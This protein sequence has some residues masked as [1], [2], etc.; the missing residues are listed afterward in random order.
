MRL[1]MKETNFLSP[2]C[3]HG[4]LA[5]ALGLARCRPSLAVY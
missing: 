2:T 1:V 5:L 3:S 4:L